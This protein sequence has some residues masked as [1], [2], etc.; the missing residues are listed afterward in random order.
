MG[1]RYCSGILLAGLQ[2]KVAAIIFSPASLPD[3]VNFARDSE[4]LPL[5]FLHHIFSKK[6][7]E[8]HSASA[9]SLWSKPRLSLIISLCQRRVQA[10]CTEKPKG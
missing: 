8:A 6:G 7:Q 10:F 1:S 5:R 9:P 3:F 4:I 2:A